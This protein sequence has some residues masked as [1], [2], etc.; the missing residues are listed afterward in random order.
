MLKDKIRIRSHPKQVF[1]FAYRSRHGFFYENMNPFAQ[2]FF[3][4]F[5]MKTRGN[6]NADGVRPGPGDKLVH[7]GKPGNTE[8]VSYGG[9]PAFIL[10]DYTDK[11]RP[12]EFCVYP[13]MVLSEIPDPDNTQPFQVHERINSF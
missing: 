3:R 8:I 5:K 4:N 9:C 1:S 13:S 12:E 2:C 7:I 11:L 6:H 10:I